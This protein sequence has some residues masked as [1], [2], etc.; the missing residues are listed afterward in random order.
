MEDAD[1][2]RTSDNQPVTA[3]VLADRVTQ[4]QEEL[5]SLT[6]LLYTSIGVLQRD[7][8]PLELTSDVPTLP[9]EQLDSVSSMVEAVVTSCRRIDEYIERLPA[10]DEPIDEKLQAA[11]LDNRASMEELASAAD[12]AKAWLS[13]LRSG[14]ERLSDLRVAQ[15]NARASGA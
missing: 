3:P 9:A 14:V 5:D 11:E 13:Q 1:G 6:Q 10:H 4:L 7:A 15:V 8:P 12:E 2:A